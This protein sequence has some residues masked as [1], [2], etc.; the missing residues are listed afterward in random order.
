[1]ETKTIT[2]AEG[3]MEFVETLVGEEYDGEKYQDKKIYFVV[4]NGDSHDIYQ[5]K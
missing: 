3:V 2:T 1:M 5:K 4:T